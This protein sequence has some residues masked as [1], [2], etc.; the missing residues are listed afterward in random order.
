MEHDDAMLEEH[1]CSVSQ[2]LAEP[3][4]EIRK[5]FDR[6]VRKHP[7]CLLGNISPSNFLLP[8]ETHARKLLGDY[9]NGA[10]ILEVGCGDCVDSVTLAGRHNRVWAIDI[11]E[12]RLSDGRQN[13]ISAGKADQVFPLCMD[14][15]RLVFSD[16]T[17]D[18]VVG[19]SVLLFLDIE[20]FAT[21]CYRV[22]KPGGRAIFPNESMALHPL[23]KLR[24]ALPQV[25][26]RERITR[27]ITI[28]SINHMSRHFDGVMHRE[29]YLWSVLLAPLAARYGST[30]FGAAAIRFAHRFDDFL[31]RIFPRFRKYCW[32][33]VLEF[34][35]A[36]SP[37]LPRS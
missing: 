22:L 16:N 25:S 35:K 3:C 36:A 27:R 6:E 21:E 17:F 12:R 13:V 32:I 30:R 20:L 2:D 1:P 7:S 34:R 5:Y 9:D 18:L 29:F 14:A 31:L 26:A 10:C 11:S 37:R 8:S 33:S 4:R 15:T 23:M 28:D 24:R 19:N